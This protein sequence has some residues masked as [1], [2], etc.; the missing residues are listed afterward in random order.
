ML[1]SCGHDCHQMNTT[2]EP[3]CD[4]SLL[5]SPSVPFRFRRR[6][7]A[8]EAAL[9]FAPDDPAW[10]KQ[11]VQFHGHLGPWAA[12]GLRLG[13]AGKDAVAAEGYFDV[14]VVIEG[15]FVKP[16]SSCFL[17][18]VQVA[19]GATWGKRNIEW[20]KAES[21]VLRVKNTRT[22]RTAEVRP[23]P[24]LL[25]L[26]TSF[27][28]KP[29]VGANVASRGREPARRGTGIAGP[30]D[31]EV[32][33]AR[34]SDGESRGKVA[35]ARSWAFGLWTWESDSLPKPLWCAGAGG[36]CVVPYHSVDCAA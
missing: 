11:A 10:L 35:R 6:A 9:R 14:E 25:K 18:G 19:T 29:K 27:K 34:D 21:I 33:G 1:Y 32:A 36:H 3:P 2:A 7:D 8:A 23:T 26:A 24:A 31:C 17:D 16:P 20:L 28:P 15:P 13:L 12:A 22:G 4:C 5:S 30:Q